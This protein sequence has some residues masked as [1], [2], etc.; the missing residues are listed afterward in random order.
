MVIP[1]EEGT[2]VV[3]DCKRKEIIIRLP[4]TVNCKPGFDTLDELFVQ[5]GNWGECDIVAAIQK[6]IH[7]IFSCLVNFSTNSSFLLVKFLIFY[8]L[9][10]EDCLNPC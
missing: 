10:I 9:R 6:R 7:L 4:I 2:Y 5:D 1:G 3:L 8:T